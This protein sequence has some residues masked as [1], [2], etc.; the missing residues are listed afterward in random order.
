MLTSCSS[1]IF[2][3]PEGHLVSYLGLVKP[4]HALDWPNAALGVL[5]YVVHM[6][7]APSKLA[8][9]AS[10]LGLSVS[11]FLAYQLTFV[12]KELC[13]LCFSTHIINVLLVYGN[14]KGSSSKRK[15]E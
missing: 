9:A 2:T 15:T 6:I 7:L 13:V 4:G 3:L 14:L 12:L 1:S 11:I 10:L 8:T 5:F